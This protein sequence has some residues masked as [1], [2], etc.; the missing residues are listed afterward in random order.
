MASEYNITFSNQING[1]ALDAGIYAL[2]CPMAFDVIG[3]LLN[4]V[5]YFQQRGKIFQF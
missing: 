1:R 2:H 3:P 4:K 5:L